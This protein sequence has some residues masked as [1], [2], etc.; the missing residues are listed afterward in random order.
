MNSERSVW[1]AALLVIGTLA[2]AAIW[3]VVFATGAEPDVSQGASPE[4]SVEPEPERPVS[5]WVGDSYT[6]GTGAD[7]PET[8]ESCLT[9]EKMGWE[10]VLDA[11]GGTG[12][13]TDGVVDGFSPFIKR[14]PVTAE[15]VDPD[16][17][18]VD[19]GRNDRKVA[20][21]PEIEKA[22][23]TYFTRLRAAYPDVQLVQI[24]PFAM[25]ED[26]EVFD[27]E[28]ADV[29]A[30]LMREFDGHVIDPNGD[31]WAGG[32]PTADLTISDGHPNQAGHAYLARHFA[33]ELR[34]L[35][36]DVH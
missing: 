12:F 2:V 19:G 20:D 36:L 34:A 24:V 11:E 26:A 17:V 18:I 21:L 33:A 23:R 35:R 5:L 16:I 3:G 13:L 1:P 7:S 30:E 25:T 14:L 10:C 32:K 4:L 29:A 31:G 15:T 9:A 6:A 22:M 8:A 27:G 28:F